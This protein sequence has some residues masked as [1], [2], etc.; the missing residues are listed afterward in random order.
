MRGLVQAHDRSFPR[1][2]RGDAAD[3]RVRRLEPEVAVEPEQA[4]EVHVDHAAVTDDRN[5]TAGE[6]FD[7]ARDSGDDPVAELLRCLAAELLPAAV[8]HGLPAHVA[9][10]LELLGRDVVVGAGVVLDE[11]VPNLDL[12]PVDGRDRCRGLAGPAQR[13][14]D[15][16]IEVLAREPRRQ[17]LRLGPAP[18]REVGVDGTTTTLTRT[19]AHRL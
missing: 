14:G 7:D 8:E 12:E 4:T 2:R 19:D 11:L 10:R 5:P 6:T 18:R 15:D 16:G 17:S 1:T 9:R 13:A 3:R